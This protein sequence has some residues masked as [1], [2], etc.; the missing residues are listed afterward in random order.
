MGTTSTWIEC[1]ISTSNGGGSIN[2]LIRVGV[3]TSR[4]GGCKI[5]RWWS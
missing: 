2:T 3:G 1:G 4:G 5:G